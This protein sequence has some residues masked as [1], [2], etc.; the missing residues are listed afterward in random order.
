MKGEEDEMDVSHAIAECRRMEKD[1]EARRRREKIDE[2]KTE[3]AGDSIKAMA[4]LNKLIDLVIE[5]Q[6][7]D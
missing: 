5:D 2:L 7:I 4:V 6:A 3:I 1:N